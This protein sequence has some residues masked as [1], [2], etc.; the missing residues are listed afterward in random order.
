MHQNRSP[1][2]DESRAA[3]LLGLAADERGAVADAGAAQLGQ[4]RAVWPIAMAA[5][6]VGAAVLVGLPL[7]NQVRPSALGLG[8][9]GLVIALGG[10]IWAMLVLPVSNAWPIHR[11]NRALTLLAGAIAGGLLMLLWA[12]ARMPVGPQQLGSFVAAAGAIGIT[13]IALQ[14]VRAATLGFGAGLVVA[15]MALAG[16]GPA[17]AI[18][19]AFLGCLGL[20]ARRLAHHDL[21]N[22]L[23]QAD[24]ASEGQ[25]AVK[26]VAEFEGQG[27]GWFWEADRHGRIVYLSGTVAAELERVGLQPIGRPRPRCSA[28]TA[29]RRKRSARSPSTSPRAPRSATTPSALRR[30][31]RSSA[32]GRSPAGPCSTPTGASPA[33]SARART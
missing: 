21:E 3:V 14:P 23:K 13:A 10:L 22:A 18:S 7:F 11:I 31:G 19:A 9:V 27:T 32:G 5:Q 17:I 29:R 2:I 15:L 20:C 30:R 33:S 1:S 25:L 4:V 24:A 26:M 8:G 12:A 28:S 16:F 6:G